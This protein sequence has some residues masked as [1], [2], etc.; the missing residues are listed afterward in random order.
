M[1]I[2]SILF[3]H[4]GPLL[5]IAVS[6]IFILN[7]V[8]IRN[9][10][11][12]NAWQELKKTEKEMHR[13]AQSLLNTAITNYLRGITETSLTYIEHQYAAYMKGLQ[14][15]N[16]AKD[17][18][19]AYFTR[20]SVGSS[21]YIVA[22]CEQGDQLLLDI[23][24]YLRKQDCTDVEGCM[25]WAKVRHGYTEYNW[26]NPEDNS[27]RKKAAY[28]VEFPEWNWIVGASSYRDEFV[29]LVDIED[30]RALIKPVKIMKSGYFLIFDQNDELLIHPAY[31]TNQHAITD[32]NQDKIREVIQSLKQTPDGF[33]TYSWK[34]PTDKTERDKFAFMEKLDDFG[35]YLVAT[36][37]QDEIF[38]PIRSLTKITFM[39]VLLAGTLLLLIIAR[40][41]RIISIPLLLLEEAVSNFY[42]DQKPFTWQEHHVDEIN[43]VGHAFSRMSSELNRTM[44]DLTTNITKLALSEQE[45]EQSRMLLQSIIDAMSSI[46]IGVDSTLHIN[47]LNSQG[48]KTLHS[49]FNEVHGKP[50][51]SM[52][53]NLLEHREILVNSIQSNT[54]DTISY[55]FTDEMGNTIYQ[56][57]MVAPFST[58]Q[59]GGAVI[60][61]DDT[62][63]QAEIEQRLRH[64]Q[65]MDA[66]GQLA[67]GI[68]HDFNNMLG[69]IMGAADILQLKVGEKE[70]RLVQIIRQ[71]SLRASELIQKLL[72]F[73][74][75]EKIAFT[76]V[77]LH[78]VI[79]D[80]A[81]ILER[82]LDKRIVIEVHTKAEKHDIS[83]DSSQL[84][85]CLLNLGINA[86][87]AMPEGG[88][89]TIDTT[90]VDLNEQDCEEYPFPL[91][92]GRFIKLCIRDTGCGISKEH[93][94]HI[95][96]P[97]F[98]TREAD[99]GT[100]LG[101]AAVYGA[102]QQHNGAIRVQ[103]EP[104][105][106]TEFTL[107]FPVTEA[108]P[109][110][111]K[112]QANTV[113]GSGCILI[114]DDEQV[115]RMTVRMML[116]EFGYTTLE[117]KN[118][119]HGLEIYQQNQEKIDLVI[120]DMIMP[121]MDG[122][123]C[124]LALKRIAP[125]LPI[126]IS[127]GFTRD[128][129]LNTLKKHGLE[130]IIRKPYNAEDLSRAVAQNL[131][132]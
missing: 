76:V 95:F 26:K 120:L 27:Q 111:E 107:L 116:E 85:N 79:G 114:V 124:F 86:G 34:N 112:A 46:I 64:S 49:S 33:L 89:L 128:A 66:I 91:N 77:D 100:G 75:K 119:Q 70:K 23:H 103:S 6:T 58:E 3:L 56:D 55:T 131:K 31:E 98:T 25:V 74:R 44:G 39:V 80:T 108:S 38:E 63:K 45:T 115:V 8:L 93:I 60:R 99:K 32:A 69:G 122:T 110:K 57:L 2:R 132:Q 78:K 47:Q 106:G 1:K 82:T 17:S 101:L 88:T 37:Y 84:L 7:Y 126:I 4:I 61:I 54:S 36:G 30:L 73:S 97:F 96:E 42:K 48:L 127:S 65:K 5:L 18:I 83:G 12:E 40:L 129:D 15:E 123:E 72:A 24:P 102:V 53:P 67:G 87:H 9:S 113:E 51:F 121:V 94:K 19:Q 92:S 22:V 130:T 109:E 90:N 125:D 43:V 28:L 20:M 118:G 13:A 105:Q 10:L 21:G 62:T 81:K 16:Q 104:G 41:S 29:D 68:A 117:A 14:T 59:F 50:L 52:F 35:W 71:A 11:K